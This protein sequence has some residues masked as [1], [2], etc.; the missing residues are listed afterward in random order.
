MVCKSFLNV[1][2]GVCA[3]P[4]GLRTRYAHLVLVLVVDGSYRN[5]RKRQFLT[6]FYRCIIAFEENTS[7]LHSKTVMVQTI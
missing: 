6:T 3:E 7:V 2:I 5:Q 1:V 4:S